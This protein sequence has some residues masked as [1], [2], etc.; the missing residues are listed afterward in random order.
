MGTG[1]IAANFHEGSRSEYLA[2]YVFAS[3]G[4]AV[5]VSHQEDS[6][7]DLNCG[8]TERVGQRAWVRAYYDVQVKSTVGPWHFCGRDSVRW[9]LE[10]PV[11]LF[12]CVVEKD[13]ARLRIYQ[14]SS[15]FRP[16][17][18]AGVDEIVLDHGEDEQPGSPPTSSLGLPIVDLTVS[19]LL[20]DAN[21]LA[22]RRCLESWIAIDR[23]N[24]WRRSNGQAAVMV[25]SRYETN[26]VPFSELREGDGTVTLFGPSLPEA[27]PK[28][29]ELLRGFYMGN[30]MTMTPQRAAL[31][32]MLHRELTNR[33]GPPLG[34]VEHE[35][36]ER[37]GTENY[38]FDA[39]DRLLDGVASAIA[40]P[41][42]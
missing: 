35:L 4:T 11:P 31:L 9:L 30:R 39:V 2:Q 13:E 8:L 1:S 37:I 17:L 12:L 33:R 18:A 21:H 10:H 29:I 14:T 27:L 42:P 28:L 40:A 32:A 3:F 20:Q 16:E 7:I 6:G 5:A 41:R 38:L 23:E 15:R 24:I 25:P 34:F 26:K 36:H 19:E 22:A